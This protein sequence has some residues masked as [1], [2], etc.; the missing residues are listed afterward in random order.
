MEWYDQRSWQD[1][2]NGRP[3]NVQVRQQTLMVK[4]LWEIPAEI[5]RM[6]LKN[7]GLL[8]LRG[9]LRAF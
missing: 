4:V 8:S 6:G 9:F 5:L 2:T 1:G 7:Q 3:R